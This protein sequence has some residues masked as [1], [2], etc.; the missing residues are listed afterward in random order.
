M[1]ETQE[2]R[3]LQ[4]LEENDRPVV[5]LREPTVL[6]VR[7]GSVILHGSANARV[8]RRGNPPVEIPPGTNLAAELR[9]ERA[10]RVE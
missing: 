10:A 6:R 1:G 3:I 2:E 7:S 9:R 8:F 5:G 4:Y